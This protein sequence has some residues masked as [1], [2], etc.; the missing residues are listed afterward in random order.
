[1]TA[2]RT[3]PLHSAARSGRSPRAVAHAAQFPADL[4]VAIVRATL[5]A[6][7]LLLLGTAIAAAQ[8]APA[9]LKPPNPSANQTSQL[10]YSAAMAAARAA[11]A[12]PG[13]SQTATM[14][15]NAAIER[16]RMHDLNGARSAAVQA[17]IQANQPPAAALSPLRPIAPQRSYVQTVAPPLLGTIPSI[18]AQSFVAQAR[19]S[20][21][22]CR[23]QHA[24]STAAASAQLDAASRDERAG[25]FASAQT[26]AKR[27]IALCAPSLRTLNLQTP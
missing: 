8:A 12:N 1:M 4:L 19:A 6:A 25:K 3:V 13:A 24:N 14:D 15:A 18:D 17:L 23:E 21:N 5:F 27:A 26:E 20:V 16:Y 2:H 10:V 22:A 7:V 9:P 11:A